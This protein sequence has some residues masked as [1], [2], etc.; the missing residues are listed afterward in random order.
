MGWEMRWDGHSW[1]QGA[2]ALGRLGIGLV[3]KI[4]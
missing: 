3:D 2:F 1:S 4:R